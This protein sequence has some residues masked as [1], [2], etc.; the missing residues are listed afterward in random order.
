MAKRNSSSGKL[1]PYVWKVPRSR[2]PF[3]VSTALPDER[4]GEDL[5]GLVQGQPATDIEERLYRALN[6]KYGPENVEFQPSF[7]AGRNVPGEIRPDFVAYGGLIYIYY[8]DGDYFH[9]TT[10]QRTRDETSDAILF[11]EL[12]GAAA[13]P[14]RISGDDL[15]NQEDANEAVEDSA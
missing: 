1:S 9:R 14:I 6:K 15:S 10:E 13:F 5:V 3:E 2:P 4:Q 11:E 8:A 7:I 12:A